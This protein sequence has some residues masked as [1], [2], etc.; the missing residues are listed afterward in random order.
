MN[1][2]VRTNL[3]KSR[4]CPV[5][6]PVGWCYYGGRYFLRMIRGKRPVIHIGKTVEG[7]VT[8][9]EL[10]REFQLFEGESESAGE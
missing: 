2:V 8:R 3:P 7:A 1:E 5:L 9:K 10:Y 6:L 4:K